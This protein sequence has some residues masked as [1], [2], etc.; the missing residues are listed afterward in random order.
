MASQHPSSWSQ[1]LLWVEYALHNTLT[2]SATGLS[3]F[4]CA[5][6]FQPPLFPDLEEEVSCP[7]VQAFIRRC[8]GT[9]TQA[10]AALLYSSDPDTEAA[11]RRR[12]Q[13]PTYQGRPKGVALH[14]GPTSTSRV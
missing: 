12:S 7:S 9:W 3:P 1:Q 11:N 14:T 13:A 8:R 4:Q 5:Y 2:C 10:R 6:G